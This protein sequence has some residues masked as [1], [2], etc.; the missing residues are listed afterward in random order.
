M[1]IPEKFGKYPWVTGFVAVALVL[2]L[3]YGLA[4]IFGA[5]WVAGMIEGRIDNME[6]GG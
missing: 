5:E 4:D 3:L 2:A 1:N 6:G